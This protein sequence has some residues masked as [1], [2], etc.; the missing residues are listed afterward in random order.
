M[1]PLRS[2]LSVFVC[3]SLNDR[4]FAGEMQDPVTLHIQFE[5]SIVQRGNDVI[6]EIS[7][8]NASPNT[9][10]IPCARY[11]Y[12]VW[13]DYK[14]DVEGDNGTIVPLTRFGENFYGTPNEEMPMLHNQTVIRLGPLD[15]FRHEAMLS[16]V[17]TLNGSGSYTVRATRDLSDAQGN[18]VKI[19]SN[20]ATITIGD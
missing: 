1:K 19:S 3:L 2:L 17:F 7:L 12:G 4:S 11:D 13:E 20:L 9:L 8:E 18:T 14:F 5:H 10:D 6:L 16:D 15:E